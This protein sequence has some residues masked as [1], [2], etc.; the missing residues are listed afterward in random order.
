M[1]ILGKIRERSLFLI[2]VIAL[3]LFSFVIGDVFTRG[4]MGGNKNSVGEINSENIS[5]E[6]FSQL[7]E[8][9][10]ARTG[11]RGSQLQSV[12]AA[13]DNLVRE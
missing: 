2:I 13:W 8:Q 4:G 10:R 1:A 9:E 5:I 3:A 6:E 12:N 7:V 11:T